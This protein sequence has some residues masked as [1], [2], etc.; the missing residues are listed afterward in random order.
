MSPPTSLAVYARCSHVIPLRLARGYI[1][2]DK[3]QRE[4]C[5]HYTRRRRCCCFVIVIGGVIVSLLLLV[6]GSK[7]H[8]ISFHYGCLKKVYL[9]L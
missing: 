5:G 7:Y 4:C 9:H 8:L 2:M 1:P 6:V 3:V